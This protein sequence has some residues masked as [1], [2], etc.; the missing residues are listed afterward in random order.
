MITDY[1][2]IA[3]FLLAV[4]YVAHRLALLELPTFGAVTA[5]AIALIARLTTDRSRDIDEAIREQAISRLSALGMPQEVIRIVLG[6]S[7][8]PGLELVSSPNCLL[9]M[10]AF[11]TTDLTL[12]KPA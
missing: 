8:P 3:V 10:P 4:S 5:S 12:S 9:S 7:L 1:I 6:E 2:M 11:Q